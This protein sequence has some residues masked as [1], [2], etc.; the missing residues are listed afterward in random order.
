MADTPP[1]W[2]RAE[3]RG[4]ER[5]APLVPEHARILVEQGFEIVVEDGAQRV[6]PAEAYAEAGCRI[7][8]A[9]SWVR[10]P[11]DYY[12]LGLKELPE[13][14]AALTHRHIYFGHA[15]K[16]Q[17]GA[18]A[19]L[20]RFTKG[21]GTLLDLEYLVDER[22]RR[23]AAFG[24]WAG[25]VGAALALLHH[26][27]RLDAPLAPTSKAQ[28]DARL[29]ALRPQ[30]V[31]LL[32]LGALGRGGRGACDAALAAGVEPTR[33]DLAE[34]RRLRRGELLAHD[35]LVNTVLT[36]TPADPFLTPADLAAPGRR[37]SVVCDVTC[38]LGSPYNLLPVYTELTGWRQPARALPGAEPPADV[39]AIDNLPSLLPE[40]ASTAF[41]GELSALLAGLGRGE[42][43][44]RRSAEAFRGTCARLELTV[45]VR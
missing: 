37:L 13:E 45:E 15:Y 14:P 10:A 29:A 33:W 28:L 11:Q 24:Y 36:T 41:S 8:P 38:D 12:I 7:E 5:R 27:G 3:H 44:W 40:E 42:P 4:T 21:G 39:I 43:A 30:G 34:T 6:F 25:Y 23:L 17:D 20:R 35:I 2:M 22:G 31:R 18:P 19:L 1:L 32:A 26:A 9:G 16:D